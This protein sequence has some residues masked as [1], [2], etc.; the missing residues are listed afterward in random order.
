MSTP[1]VAQRRL[2]LL[3]GAL[4]LL[5]FALRL[6]NLDS[7]SFW[8]DE[9]LTP[10]RSSYSI[11]QILTNRIYIQEAISLDT[12][13]PLYYLLIHATRRLWGETD[14]AYRYP[15]LLAGVLL[16]PLLYQFGRRLGGVRAGVLTAVFTAVNPLQVYYGN[17]ARMYTLLV[18]LGAAAS[19]VLWRALTGADLRRSLFL[20]VLLAG[21]AF[22]THYT[23]VFLIAAQALFW[24]WLLWQQGYK[25]LILGLGFLALLLAIPVVPYTLPRLFTGA[26]ANYFVV[27]PATMISDVWRFFSLGLSV[28]YKETLVTGILVLTAVLSFIGLWAAHT[29]LKRSFLLVYL[30]AV[31]F[32]LMAGSLLKPMYQGVRHIMLGSP[33]LL[34]LLGMGADYLLGR[35]LQPDHNARWLWRAATFVLLLTPL[36]GS[37]YALDNLY[38]DPQ[39]GKDDLR[40]LVAYVERRAGDRDVVLYNNAVLLPLHDHYQQRSDLPATALPVYPYMADGVEEQLADLAVQYDRIWFVTDPPADGRDADY[41]VAGWLAENLQDIDNQSFP[42]RTT[43]VS[44][45]GYRS[46]TA[47]APELPPGSTSLNLTWPGLPALRGV[48]PSFARPATGTTLW[49]DLFW[50]G[51]PAPPAGST[52]R[53]SLQGEGDQPWAYYEQAF[54]DNFAH[55]PVAGLLRESYKL[56]LPPGTPPGTY[57]LLAEPA[58]PAGH[59]VGAAQAVTDIILAP[60]TPLH[61]RPAVSFANGITLHDIEWGDDDV[62]PGHNL[63]L[64]L[65]W[66]A[67]AEGSAAWPDARYELQVL[68]PGGTLLRS[69]GGQPGGSDLAHMPANTAVREATA[70]YFPPDTVPGNYRL[71]WQMN[72]ADQPVGARSGW[73][74]WDRA[75]VVYGTVDVTPWP[76]ETALPAGLTP[77]GAQFGEAIS[78]AG[79]TLAATPQGIELELVWQAADVPAESYVAFVHVVD[80]A[81]GMIISQ[82]DR[83]PLDGLRPTTGWR[84]EEVL[85][86]RY[87]LALPD[88]I[89]GEPYRINVGLYNPDDGQRL[90][91]TVDGVA[92]PD[93]QLALVTGSFP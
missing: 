77:T 17:E 37:L 87:S 75:Q 41:R 50:E 86:D 64:A 48:L 30:L 92:Q 58:D 40:A 89:A 54:S 21:S 5:A 88:D 26:E 53:L 27:P 24:I 8:T 46:A 1:G 28:N 18:L 35:R 36:V 33:A 15:S 81:T 93:N 39:F 20:Y 90:P 13:P 16:V 34:L 25:R 23:A 74:P 67:T 91:V 45:I 12:H 62:R 73:L 14:F 70:I 85:V 10:L 69:Q 61:G 42:A 65:L 19:Y 79:Y 3:V 47:A 84:K 66:Q 31:V 76:L 4:T 80:P 11:S 56:P 52:L 55:W 29:W 6:V 83:V 7:F 51:Q 82:A 49:L 22:Y 38:R 57:T 72:Q 71:Q 59:N 68:G 32:G 60:A 9:G 43:V 63:P 44:S 2:L 78:L